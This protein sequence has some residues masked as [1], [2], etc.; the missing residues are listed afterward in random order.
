MQCNAPFL[1]GVGTRGEGGGDLGLILLGRQTQRFVC[2]A[3]GDATYQKVKNGDVTN[4]NM[5]KVEIIHSLTATMQFNC[6]TNAGS[7]HTVLERSRHNTGEPLPRRRVCVSLG[8]QLLLEK[9]LLP[10]RNVA[11]SLLF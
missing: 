11:T 4:V 2:S 3:E 1:L 10:T 7:K 9:A 5:F 8:Q 6:D